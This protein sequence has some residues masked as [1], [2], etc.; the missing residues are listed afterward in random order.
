MCC[1]LHGGEVVGGMVTVYCVGGGNDSIKQQL[2]DES[3]GSLTSI[4]CSLP[5]TNARASTTTTSSGLPAPST[6]TFT[7]DFTTGASPA[8]PTSTATAP[9]MAGPLIPAASSTPTLCTVVTCSL[10][11]SFPPSFPVCICP[12]TA[13]SLAF[14]HLIQNNVSCLAPEGFIIMRRCQPLDEVGGV[15]RGSGFRVFGEPNKT[16]NS[17]VSVR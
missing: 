8:S 2:I 6:N 14:P 16:F 13:T 17:R 9:C 10:R 4:A 12:L 3:V 11:R 7:T 1:E 15:L 5:I